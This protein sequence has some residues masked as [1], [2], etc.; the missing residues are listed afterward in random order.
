M[1]DT[2]DNSGDLLLD[3]KEKLPHGE[4]NKKS[5]RRNCERNEENP[6][7]ERE[8]EGKIMCEI[9]EMMK[10][11]VSDK[12]IEDIIEYLN[13]AYEMEYRHSYHNISLTIYQ[14]LS[15]SD[16]SLGNLSKNVEVLFN[17]A[18]DKYNKQREVCNSFKKLYDHI[19][20]EIIRINDNKSSI[21]EI[22]GLISAFREEAENNIKDAK[23]ESRQTISIRTRKTMDF[24]E[25][26][27]KPMIEEINGLKNG[28][29]NQTMT[30]LG[31]FSAIVLAFS[32]GMVYSS[33]VLENINKS[34]AYRILFI[35]VAIGFTL[36]NAI[37]ALLIY[38]GKVINPTKDREKIS[39]KN[40]LIS[41]LYWIIVNTIFVL[42][43]IAIIFKWEHSTE[44]ALNEQS[45]RYYIEK[46]SKDTND[47]A[48][49]VSGN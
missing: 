29:I 41:N 42:A 6:L 49:S 18:L 26:K 34:S 13:N 37:I 30:I 24:L 9:V 1:G 35:C 2:K 39:L 36:V 27:T 23:K 19:S 28:L 31:I 8:I 40:F 25:E 16:D 7:K 43:A 33:S 5:S 44:K 15:V 4:N 17:R 20:L 46:L 12:F 48:G 10:G 22:R 38:L 11:D 3:V 32:G 45:N 21:R 47:I 14:N